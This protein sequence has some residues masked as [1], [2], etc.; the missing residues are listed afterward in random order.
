MEHVDIRAAQSREFHFGEKDFDA[1]ANMV[2][3]S[4]GILLTEGKAGLV[5]GRLAKFVRDLN[6]SSFAEYISVLSEDEQERRRAIFALTT[7]HTRFFRENHHFEHLRDEVR[8]VLVERALQ[9]GRVRLWSAACSSGEEP[10]SAAMT[11]LG[12]AK[13]EAN[14]LLNSDFKILATDLAPQ[15]LTKARSGIYPLQAR[16]DIPERL[17]K[18]WSQ[19]GPDGLRMSQEI[20][21][22][23]T[24]R[25]L[26]FLD[27]WPMRGKFDVIFCRNVMIYFDNETKAQLL[28]RL[29]D[30]LETGGYLYIGHSERVLGRAARRL[31]LTGPTTYCKVD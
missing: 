13:S 17:L 30:Q 10:Y 18:L 12:D 25:Q 19:Q 27:A 15:V 22:M 26:N 1:I 16:A 24:F 21:G 8:P 28:D 9:G 4:A 7:N 5:Y 20:M 2:H 31:K 29:V 14:N 23:T 3:E 11:L 6:L